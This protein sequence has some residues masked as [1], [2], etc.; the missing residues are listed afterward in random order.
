MATLEDIV[1]T[2]DIGIM[3]HID[4]GKTTTT[5]RILFYTGIT[6][7]I[8]EVHDGAAVMDYMPQE[9]ERGITIT[10]AATTCYWR[11]HRINIIDTPGHVDFT[12]E[13]ER[14]LRVL[15]GAIAVFDAVSGVEPQSE[16]VW[17][18]ADRYRVPRVAFVNKLDRVGATLELTVNMLRER[19]G[20]H[21]IVVQL[22]IGLE[23]AFEGVIDLLEMQALHF[24]GE[25]G[26]IVRADP[27]TPD[28][29]YF[30]AAREARVALVE[31][32]A[33]VDAELEELYLSDEGANV[34]AQTL[35]EGLRRATV[36][37]RGVPVLC[38]SSLKNKG[39][40]PL[41][42]AVVDYLPSPRDLPPVDA[43]VVDAG[44]P[45]GETTARRPIHGDP[46]LALAFKVLYDPHRG[47]LVFFRVYSGKAKIKDAVWNVTRARK[48]RLQKILQVH[49]NKTQ[50]IDTVG[51]GD[52]A[53]A[54]G[55]K[56]TAT[57]D[58]LV[59]ADDAQRVVL[60]GMQ[61]PEPVIFRSIEP[62]TASD[63]KGLDEAL[64]RFQRED[65]SFKVRQDAD[66]GQTLVCGQG[67]LHLEVIID[68]LLREHRLDVHVG[69]PQVAY[70]ETISVPVDRELEYVREI[71][72][73]RQYAK[74]TLRFEPVGR[75]EGNAFVDAL[76]PSTAPSGAR[77]SALRGGPDGKPGLDRVFLTAIR[78]SVSDGMTRG[79]LL[80]FPVED[81][82]VTL[83]H[84]VAHDQESSEASFR[85]A[86]S[87]ATMEGLEAARPVLLEP[88]MAIDVVVPQDFT[89]SVVSD[90]NG[91]RGRVMGMEAAPGSRP[92]SHA[93]SHPG[94]H[95]GQGG[96]QI[97]KAE[98]PLAAMVGYATELRSATQ[99]RA[100]YSMH[101]SHNA[102]VSA[103]VQASIVQ[104]LRGY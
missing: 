79:P 93:G 91:R 85:A 51:P 18:Q 47:P 63:Q 62:K 44:G 10:A 89:G 84:A 69:R 28:S 5:E 31:A 99:G 58:T 57:G 87:M 60:A 30:E 71:G 1:R 32:L 21:P 38:G 40:Q 72:G 86:A 88:I 50:E 54:V 2:R 46:F 68:R 101:Y 94:S 82:R 16:T 42:D 22:P 13:V 95:P 3:A 39:V 23:G 80:G 52:I 103:E 70:R 48:E 76:P 56:F 73:K 11:E 6:H 65:P 55:L 104:R 26:E 24:D 27:L 35:R 25:H 49:A 17:R 77:S 100:A 12:V 59:L 83:V 61:I 53:A 36:S 102:E 20:A 81:V 34:T 4:A 75:G 41:L 66:S 90:L 43:E 67:E 19:L 96:N 64:E 37:G 7:R 74:L 33:E 78:E 8:G 98:V 9:Q 97:V 15:D 45:T 14:S 92:D 29:E